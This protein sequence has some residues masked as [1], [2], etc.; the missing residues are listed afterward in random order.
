MSSSKPLHSPL[1]TTTH[2]IRSAII[3]TVA[4][5]V[6]GIVAAGAVVISTLASSSGRSVAAVLSPGLGRIGGEALGGGGEVDGDVSVFDDDVPAIANLDPALLDAIR[7]AATDAA[8]DDVAF[9]VN[10]GWRSPGYQEQ[11]LREAV[12]EYGSEAEAARWVATAETSPHVSGDAIDIGPFD[13]TYW[14]SQHGAEYGLC[15]I[16]ANESWHVE[17]RP[18]AVAD[19][20]PAMYEDPTFD[21]RMRQ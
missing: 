18:D 17:L 6:T 12:D 1:R 2:R 11:L 5:A 13:A 9:T 20:C 15:Q 21:P 16:Y 19:G 4:M 8:L 3:I 14:L 10:S 7:R